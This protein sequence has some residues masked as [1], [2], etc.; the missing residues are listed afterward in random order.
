MLDHNYVYLSV[1]LWAGM[2]LDS[3]FMSLEL[4]TGPGAEQVPQEDTAGI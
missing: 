4:S 2:G 3:L 1:S